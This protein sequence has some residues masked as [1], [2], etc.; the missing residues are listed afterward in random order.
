MTSREATVHPMLKTLGYPVQLARLR[1]MRHVALLTS[2][3][4]MLLVAFGLAALPSL[5]VNEWILKR[6][7]LDVFGEDTALRLIQ[8]G[9]FG[10]GL[11]LWLLTRGHYRQRLPFWTEVKHIVLGCILMLLC[12]GF[13]MFALKVDFSRL[14]LVLTWMVSAAVLP[15]GR[16]VVAALL[17][18]CG[19]WRIP[20][21]IVG[22][23]EEADDASYALRSEP[24]LGYDIL[25]T[26]PLSALLDTVT[27]R[28]W[29]ALYETHKAQLVVLALSSAEC[30]EDSDLIT[31]LVCEG[32]PFAIVPPLRGL[33]VLGFDRFY[34]FSH[35]IMMMMARNN[36]AQPMSRALKFCFDFVV[37]VLLMVLLLPLF[38][39]FAALIV[40][41]GGPVLYGHRRIGCNGRPFTCLKFRTMVGDSDRI[42][43]ELLERD[44]AVLAEWRSTFKL[45]N[46]PR[47]TRIGRFLRASSLDELPQLLNILRGEMS[48]VGP[49]PVT[50]DELHKYGRDLAFYL[51][52]RPGMTGLWQVSGRNDSSYDQRVR[53]DAWYVRNWSLWH[54]IAILAKTV[55]VVLRRVGAY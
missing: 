8:F 27:G 13:L 51:Q 52:V 46:D 17:D 19:C 37:A 30:V 2:D 33:P 29:A 3:L 14:W 31:D 41:D 26:V 36:L 35:D 45:K 12:D 38:A 24:S 32:L 20:V 43:R 25:G 9:G 1:R 34:F 49:R 42:L 50:A 18:A 10:I 39:V 47:V 7:F 28:S 22:S 53:S 21:L 40:K 55:P 23:G 54:D 48:L 44:P 5:A 4:A 15:L 6:P 11:V 16:R